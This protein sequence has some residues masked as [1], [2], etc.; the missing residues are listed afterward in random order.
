MDEKNDYF[1]YK[2][3]FFNDIDLLDGFVIYGIGEY[4]KKLIDF[5]ISIDK[6]NK[7]KGIIVTNKKDV[8][9]TYEGIP[10]KEARDF[11]V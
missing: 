7:I 8:V 1:I 2:V 11:L 9:D 6:K 5:L 4:G 3:D 10:I